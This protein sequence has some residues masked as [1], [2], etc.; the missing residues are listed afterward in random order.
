MP[1]TDLKL[2]MQELKVMNATLNDHGQEL[3]NLTKIMTSIALQKQ[4]LE[5]LELRV[6][7]AW[8]K[9]N[10]LR[11]HQQKCP[12]PQVSKLWWALGL[13]ASVWGATLANFIGHQK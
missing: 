6:S 8:A 11:D 3:K 5:A 10:V 9:L 1:D 13:L 4:R 2:V 7:D 12:R